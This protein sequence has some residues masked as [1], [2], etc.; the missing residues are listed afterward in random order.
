MKLISDPL[1]L[2]KETYCLINLTEKITG[3]TNPPTHT[4]THPQKEK[5]TKI[6][7]IVKQ[8]KVL[9]RYLSWNVNVTLGD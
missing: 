5:E 1:T 7:E 3:G 9:I 6:R 8:A 2:V 4:H